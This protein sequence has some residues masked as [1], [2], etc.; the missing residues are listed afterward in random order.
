MVRLAE[1]W[2]WGTPAGLAGIRGETVVYPDA[3]ALAGL[4]E[5]VPDGERMRCHV[6]K[7]GIQFSVDGEVL[8]EHSYCFRCNSAFAH[9]G[10]GTSF[11]FDGAS[12]A[13]TTLRAEL[14]GSFDEERGQ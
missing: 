10:H 8:A 3:A 13:A 5:S 1:D 6:P 14:A 7:Y 4:V 12:P 2:D 9:G 11:G